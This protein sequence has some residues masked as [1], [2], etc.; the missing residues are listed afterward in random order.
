MHASS[1]LPPHAEPTMEM[2]SSFLVTRIQIG[3][4]LRWAGPAETGKGRN[5]GI[6]FLVGPRG[7]KFERGEQEL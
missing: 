3:T 4:H 7:A 2:T 5:L 6:F 1:Q